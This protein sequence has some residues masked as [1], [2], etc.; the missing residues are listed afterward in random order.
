MAFYKIKS[1]TE[2]KD[3]DT[4]KGIVT[5]YASIF[6]IIDSDED[7][8]IPGAFKKTLKERGVKSKIPRIKHLWQ[9]MPWEP[10]A[11]PTILLEDDKGLYFESR[12]GNDTFSQDKLQQHVDKIITELSIGYNTIKVEK[13]M[14]GERVKYWKLLE[15]R[16]WEYSSVTW[17]S[18]HFTHIINAKGSK[19]NKLKALNDRMDRLTKA[20]ADGKYSDETMMQFQIDLKQ[21]QELYNSL[22]IKE[23]I[24]T[25]GTGEPDKEKAIKEFYRNQIK[26]T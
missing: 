7:M 2:I 4:E 18:N 21:I 14:E 12:F 26:F 16:L 3:I 11:V 23:P 15:L 20:L 24:I 9:H 19:E 22:I 6:N 8:V 17:G 10:I 25:P 5:G 13:V 1:Q